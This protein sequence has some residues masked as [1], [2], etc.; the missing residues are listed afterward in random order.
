MYD[1]VL[2]TVCV[3]V[4]YKNRRLE[5]LK[6]SH[7]DFQVLA[8]EYLTLG[9]SVARVLRNRAKV[10]SLFFHIKIQKESFC[11]FVK[12]PSIIIVQSKYEISSLVI[13]KSYA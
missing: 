10:K 1:N 13:F 7:V 6:E 11:A 8:R 4:L 5:L 2:F 12:N 9:R 3:Q